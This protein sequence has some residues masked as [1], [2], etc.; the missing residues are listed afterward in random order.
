MDG[1]GSGHGV[2]GGHGM[3]QGAPDFL[4]V[5]V[6]YGVLIKRSILTH[7]FPFPLSYYQLAVT[8]LQAPFLPHVPY[9]P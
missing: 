9:Y 6:Y 8:A 5:H 3:K 7:S 4:S 1:F 2:A